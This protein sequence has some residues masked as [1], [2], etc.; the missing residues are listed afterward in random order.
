MVV[1][2]YSGGAADLMSR[3]IIAANNRSVAERIVR[4]IQ[5]FAP[6]R[7]DAPPLQQ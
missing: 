7:D 4:E 3:R 5:P 6:P 2:V 1:R